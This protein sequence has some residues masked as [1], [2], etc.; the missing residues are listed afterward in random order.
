ML[1]QQH[2]AAARPRP[3][4][5]PHT[6]RRRRSWPRNS[7][8]AS[9]LCSSLLAPLRMR[10]RHPTRGLACGLPSCIRRPATEQSRAVQCRQAGWQ[11]AEWVVNC[12]RQGGIGGTQGVACRARRARPHLVAA[13][14]ER[15]APSSAGAPRTVPLGCAETAGPGGGSPRAQAAAGAAP[16]PPPQQRRPAVRRQGRRLLQHWGRLA[17]PLQ[18]AWPAVVTR[19]RVGFGSSRER[20]GCLPLLWQWLSLQGPLAGLPPLL[21]KV[22]A[23]GCAWGSS[24]T[25]AGPQHVNFWCVPGSSTSGHPIHRS[26]RPLPIAGAAESSSRGRG[27][28]RFCNICPLPR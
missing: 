11:L 7:Y 12:L 14:P 25:A 20:W 27:N 24:Q 8:A 4:W 28:L 18:A 10:T 16:A 21:P 13:A 2:M 19:S 5:P 1:A 17:P 9:I 26:F 22:R 15:R 23:A 3:S 6:C